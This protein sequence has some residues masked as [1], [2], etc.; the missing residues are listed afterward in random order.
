MHYLP[1]SAAVF[2]RG[3][4]WFVAIRLR[5]SG[6]ICLRAPWF[7]QHPSLP[8][9]LL[10]TGIPPTTIIGMPQ[11]SSFYLS[12]FALLRQAHPADQSIFMGVSSYF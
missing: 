7:P 2:L 5:T 11:E 1:L 9:A 10:L 6:E 8:E 4:L 12:R 3:Q